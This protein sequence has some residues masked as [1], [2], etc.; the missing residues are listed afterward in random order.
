[1]KRFNKEV[2]QVDDLDVII[3]IKAL[4]V[5]TTCKP[6]YDSLTLLPPSTFLEL[7]VRASQHILLEESMIVDGNKPD[8]RKPTANL[9][10]G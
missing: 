1:M 2:V 4:A 5:G 6:L 7:M 3:T 10:E 9:P 8:R